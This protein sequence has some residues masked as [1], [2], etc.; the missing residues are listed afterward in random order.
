MTDTTTPNT[1]VDEEAFAE[2]ER[3]VEKLRASI[4]AHQANLASAI[5]AALQPT[6]NPIL[7]DLAMRERNRG[8]FTLH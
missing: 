8:E 1:E 7:A 4:A 6:I 5:A 2:L 3:T